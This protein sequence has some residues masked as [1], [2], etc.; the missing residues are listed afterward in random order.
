[1]I[2]GN[3]GF[4]IGRYRCHRVSLTA[5]VH[6]CKGGVLGQH[7]ACEVLQR[8]T[9]SSVY[10]AAA[11]F[12]PDLGLGPLMAASFHPLSVSLWKQIALQAVY[13]LS[14]AAAGLAASRGTPCLPGRYETTKVSCFITDLGIWEWVL[15]LCLALPSSSKQS[16][17]QAQKG[18]YISL[19]QHSKEVV[20]PDPSTGLL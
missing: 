13:D 4:R 7:W 19:N 8:H 12:C 17:S 10:L 11:K 20:A 1:M 9:L 5:L 2:S 18:W 3:S 16:H 6:G 15:S 14:Q